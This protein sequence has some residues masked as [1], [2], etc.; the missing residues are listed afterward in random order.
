MVN[1]L[2]RYSSLDAYSKWLVVAVMTEAT[3]RAT[4][5]KLRQMFGTRGLPEVLVSGNSS[6]YV[7]EEFKVFMKKNGIKHV[8]ISPYHHASNGQAVGM[9]RT[10]KESLATL[11]ERDI[12]TKLD[13][14]IL[15]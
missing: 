3:A 4:V 10:F 6:A 14:H 9:V 11:K 1:S 7:G 5:I 13:R 8:Y 12:Q 15:L 2:L